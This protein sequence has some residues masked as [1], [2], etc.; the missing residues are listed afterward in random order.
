MDGS[1]SAASAANEGCPIAEAIADVR[2]RV[3]E[4][5]AKRAAG[6]PKAKL[7]AVSKTKPVSDLMAAYATGQRVF[8]EN[9]VQ[10]LIDKAPEMPDD[11]EWHF[12]GNLQSKKANSLI[13]K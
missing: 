6:V 2:K 12:I 8:G 11:V 9:Y 3:Q 7:I 13:A 5:S 4:A 10:E 1:E